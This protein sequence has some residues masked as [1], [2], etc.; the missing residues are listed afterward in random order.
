MYAVATLWRPFHVAWASLSR[1]FY[2][3]ARLRHVRVRSVFQRLNIYLSFSSRWWFN[4]KK[5]TYTTNASR[6]ELVN[7]NWPEPWVGEKF[8]TPGFP[9][10]AVHRS[11]G[12]TL[13]E[14]SSKLET[15]QTFFA[16]RFHFGKRVK[17]KRVMHI[18][19]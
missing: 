12:Q 17:T 2:I 15:A 8:N 19:F 5:S 7:N 6:Q 13:N 11:F 18:L 3:I 4:G 16:L 10:N 9:S 14:L 1:N